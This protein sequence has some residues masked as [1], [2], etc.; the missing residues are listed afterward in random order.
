M[1]WEDNHLVFE[2]LRDPAKITV[3]YSSLTSDLSLDRLLPKASSSKQICLE[4]LYITFSSDKLGSS[5]F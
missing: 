1:P 3:D 5:T 4:K 2:F